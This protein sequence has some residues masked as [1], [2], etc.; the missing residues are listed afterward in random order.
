MN[1]SMGYLKM[2]S[3]IILFIFCHTFKKKKKIKMTE[4][5]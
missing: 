5:L 3:N 1:L 2:L 4:Y